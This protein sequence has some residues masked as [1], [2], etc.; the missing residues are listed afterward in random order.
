MASPCPPRSSPR[1]SSR[2][3]SITSPHDGPALGCLRSHSQ[4]PSR[5]LKRPVNTNHRPV[6]RRR[7]PLEPSNISDPPPAV[8]LPLVAAAVAAPAV[9]TT[10][11]RSLRRS[12]NRVPCTL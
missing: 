6:K 8:Q 12:V 1:A 4:S 7:S 11:R 3:C 5:S 9:T 10:R 2:A